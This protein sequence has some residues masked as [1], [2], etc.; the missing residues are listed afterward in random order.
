MLSTPYRQRAQ[1]EDARCSVEHGPFP[2]RWSSLLIALA[3]TLLGLVLSL[4]GFESGIVRCDAGSDRCEYSRTTLLKSRPRPFS[5]SQLQRARA[6]RVESKKSANGRVELDLSDR[7]LQLGPTSESE[8]IRVAAVINEHL[9]KRSIGF[10]V[11]QRSTL[12]LAAA[13]LALLGV[14]AGFARGAL[15][16]SGRVRFDV[17]VGALRWSHRVGPLGV[18]SGSLAFA[19]GSVRDVVVTW[20]Q[21]RHFFQHRHAAPEIHGRLVLV[22]NDGSREALG[23]KSFRGHAVHL[24]GADAL[25]EALDLPPRS[26]DS[27]QEQL[28]LAAEVRPAELPNHWTGAA[29][30]GGATWIGACCGALGGMLVL[31][32]GKLATGLSSLDDSI[33]DVDLLIGAGGGALAGVWLARRLTRGRETSLE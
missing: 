33:S 28:R 16:R 11:R 19:P 10:E 27:E 2:P 23:T 4:V 17:A 31:S 32:V 5:Y 14:A 8:S 15:R 6:V 22:M 21:E 13:G 24:R 7:V 20:S 18:G 25:R 12:W 1:P 29:G 26:E 3:C 9:G 30:R